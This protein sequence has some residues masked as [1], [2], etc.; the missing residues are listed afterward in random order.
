MKL[1]CIILYGSENP[2]MMKTAGPYRIA[3]E[4]RQHGYSVMCID[5]T[6]F[7]GF[8]DDL[9]TVLN[10][11]IG[12][13]TYWV[14]ISTSFSSKHFI[15][16][17]KENQTQ[18][19]ID[20]VKG[21]NSSIKLLSG[22]SRAQDYFDYDFKIF[23]G[24]CDKEIV[25]FTD[26][27]AKKSSLINLEF[28]SKVI[29][30]SEYKDFHTSQIIYTEDDLVLSTEVLP[31][32]IARGCIFKCKFCSFQLNGKKKGDWIKNAEI[33]REELQRNYDQWG[34][35]NYMFCDDTYNDSLDKV[36][37]LYKEAFSKL[38]FKVNFGAYIRLDLLMRFPEMAQYL[39]DSGLETAVFGIE[40]LDHRNGKIVGKGVDP[41]KQLAFLS[42]LK[43]GVFKDVNCHSGFIFG[44]PHDTEESI[45]NTIEFL[46]DGD[47]PLDTVSA[48]C[49]GINPTHLGQKRDWYSDLDLNYEKFGYEVWQDGDTVKWS[50]KKN[51]LTFDKCDAL[52]KELIRRT[53]HKF[54]V[55]A[56]MFGYVKALGVP[57]EE[58]KKLTLAE[59]RKK[60]ETMNKIFEQHTTYKKKLFERILKK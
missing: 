21:L 31:I 45:R 46:I 54:Q 22:G 18:E 6:A 27:C 51:G 11:L 8:D 20:Y 34:V 40:T 55:R 25:E 58:I 41:K 60:Y 19:F 26:W 2:L 56:M 9:K 15:N 44:L 35:T 24:H 39:K 30:G 42:K 32:E 37:T 50:H 57:A 43:Q 1:N 36:K 13:E 47:H 59:V 48:F 38:T 23:K 14:G 10:T 49:L 33:L 5:T 53:D 12:N 7:N 3:T 29:N 16:N 28:Y 52:A 17:K 4:L